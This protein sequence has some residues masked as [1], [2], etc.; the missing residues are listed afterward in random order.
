MK[1]IILGF[2][3]PL[4]SGKGTVCQ[5]LKEK[6]KAGVYRFSTILR[7]VADRLYLEQS[8]NNLQN[9][10]QTLRE[11]FG[12]D[13]LAAAIA[14][15]VGNDKNP[16]IAI[17]GIRREPD[18]EYLK[19]LPGF[20]LVYIIA[21]QKI[22]WQRMVKRG[23]NTD[24]KQKTLE[25]FAKDEQGEAERQISKVAQKAK[26]KIDNNGNL[27]QLY[28]QIENILKKINES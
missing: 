18:I 7:D 6:Y 5:Y 3:G 4:S 28:Q 23:E 1:K 17:D 12:Q 2:A 20:H 10:S 22:R 27:D 9:L 8:R 11:T 16:I 24:D 14:K 13:L 26:F 15:D 19:N 25:Q 21:D